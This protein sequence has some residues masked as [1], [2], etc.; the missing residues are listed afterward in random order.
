MMGDRTY[1]Y[2]GGAIQ[3]NLMNNLS[4]KRKHD[5][6]SVYPTDQIGN[7]IKFNQINKYSTKRLSVIA[8]G[9]EISLC[10]MPTIALI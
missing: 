8:S 4:G 6:T 3:Q 1:L 5:G 9:G 2:A 7:R 10:N